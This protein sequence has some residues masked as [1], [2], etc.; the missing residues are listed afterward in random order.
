[1]ATG[2][3]GHD[4]VAGSVQEVGAELVTTVRRAALGSALVGAAG[5]CG[6]LTVAA[7]HQ[8]ALRALE[9]AMP[10]TAAAAVLTL[11]YAGGGAGLAVLG[12][13]R[14]RAA[15][16]SGEEALAEADRKLPERDA[17]SGAEG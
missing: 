7:A 10:R 15:L 9:R 14:M 3:G 5:V 6:V 4:Q 8:T 16:A 11:A 1:M 17:G 13:D 2:G 12:R